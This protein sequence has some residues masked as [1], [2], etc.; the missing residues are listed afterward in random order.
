MILVADKLFVLFL[1]F[2]HFQH[3]YSLLPVFSDDMFYCLVFFKALC[4]ITSCHL[5]LQHLRHSSVVV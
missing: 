2:L 4:A 1:F 5:H 3:S